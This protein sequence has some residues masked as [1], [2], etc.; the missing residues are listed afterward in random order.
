MTTDEKLR[1]VLA[2]VLRIPAA[3]IGDDTSTDT[4][5]AWSSLAH[6]DLILA[7]EE[8]FGITI[9]DE[10]VGDLTSFRLLKLTLEEQGAAAA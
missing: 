2:T 5:E 4:V 3:E 7:L 10:E 6:L 8:E 1:Q 9:P